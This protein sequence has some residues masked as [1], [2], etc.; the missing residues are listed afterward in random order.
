MRPAVTTARAVRDL[1]IS[2][3]L[4]AC[5]CEYVLRFCYTEL[6]HGAV[7]FFQKGWLA[8]APG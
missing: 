4:T 3:T 6:E 7:Q 5:H 2:S 8:H 1:S